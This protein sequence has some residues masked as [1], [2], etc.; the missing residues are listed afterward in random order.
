LNDFNDALID[1]NNDNSASTST[2][3]DV[4]VFLDDN[5][6]KTKNKEE[7]WLFND[8]DYNMEGDDDEY[9]DL[10]NSLPMT[11]VSVLLWIVITILNGYLLVSFSTTTDLAL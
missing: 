3:D 6:V 9:E 1:K 8:V 7:G 4:M 5:T 10:S 11:I 2:D